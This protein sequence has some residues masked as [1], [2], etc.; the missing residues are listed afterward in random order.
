MKTATL[1]IKIDPTVK[2][3]AQHL[4]QQVGLPLGS[5]INGLLKDAIRKQSVT[6]SAHR[7]RFPAEQMTPQMEKIIEQAEQDIKNGETIGPFDTV[8]DFRKALRA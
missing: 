8:E 6:F 3:D 1:S 7:E 4:A 2:H 5:L